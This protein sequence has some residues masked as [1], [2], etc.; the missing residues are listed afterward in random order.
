MKRLLDKRGTFIVVTKEKIFVWEGSQLNTD[1]REIYQAKVKE[2]V[3]F[4]QT[5]E[6]APFE[7]EYFVE[8]E[9]TDEFFEIWFK[10]GERPVI[11][12]I[13]CDW[14]VW[15]EDLDECGS[16]E[17]AIIKTKGVKEFYKYPHEEAES[18]VDIDDLEEDVFFLA[19]CLDDEANE[20]RMHVWKGID[21]D[22]SETES[23]NYM[24]KVKD[25]VFGERKVE[26]VIEEPN[27]ETEQFY[28]L[29]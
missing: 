4:L 22:I 2:H 24:N 17:I 26:V 15:Y 16:P 18:L 13:N 27:N 10:H 19:C 21:V 14:D 8:N 23:T 9:E 28:Q 6:K 7:I 20:Y 25:M 12:D 3:C 11:S 5:Y 1:E 29:L